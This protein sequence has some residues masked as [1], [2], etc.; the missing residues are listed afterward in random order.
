MLTPGGRMTDPNVLRAADVSGVVVDSPPAPD[1]ST[2]PVT[3]ASQRAGQADLVLEGGGVKGLGLVGAVLELA[4]AGYTFRRV[5][6]ASAGA[7]VATLI[8]AL[9]ARNRPVSDLQEILATIDYRKFRSGDGLIAQAGSA[10]RLLEHQGLYSGDYLRSWL[11]DRLEEIGVSKFG[12]LAITDDRLPPESRYSLVLMV[13][14]ITRGISVRLPWQYSEY[15]LAADDQLLV[16]AVR[17]SMSIPFF[18]TPERV[19]AGPAVVDGQPVP[20]QTCTWVDGGLLDNFPVDV[21][22][23]D[24]DNPVPGRWPTIGVKLSARGPRPLH[25][26]DGVIEEAKAILQTLVDNA[27]RYYVSP[28]D[29]QRT[30]FVDH[31]DVGTTDFGITAPQQAMLLA[32]G[33]AAAQA[34][35]AARPAQPPAGP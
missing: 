9:Q 29:A 7:I 24:T 25:D 21:F 8:A 18:F 16:D 19:H 11:G 35:L 10:L 12:D 3:V 1:G 2:H 20:A 15:G 13:S 17:A 6:G 26:S 22:A 30:I 14:D 33:R 5:A 32:N 28:A 23:I 27:D 4:G 34:W 31:G